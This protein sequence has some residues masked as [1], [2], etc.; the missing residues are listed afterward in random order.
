MGNIILIP[1]FDTGEFLGYM[2][3]KLEKFGL[4]SHIEEFVSGGPKSWPTIQACA[5]TW[6]KSK[7]EQSLRPN[8]INKYSGSYCYK[9]TAI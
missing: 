2:T 3:D 8:S 4:S 9:Y 5:N 6:I 7:I 1:D